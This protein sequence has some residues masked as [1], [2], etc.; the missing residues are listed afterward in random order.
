MVDKNDRSCFY[1]SMSKGEE[2]RRQ[3]VGTALRRA[4]EV[5]LEGVTVGSLADELQLSKSGLFAHFRSKEALQ[6][7]VLEEAEARFTEQ[8]VR[9]ALKAPR[10]EPRVVALFELWVRWFQLGDHPRGC[11]F[12]S[13]AAEYDDRPGAVHDGIVAS[14]KRWLEWIRGAAARAIEAGHFRADLDPGQFAFEFTAIGMSLQFQ[15]KLV[16]DPQAERRAREAFSA[17]LDRSRKAH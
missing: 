11:I 5:G 16:R 8:V 9:E 12:L 14:Q 6:L 3:I 7:A 17:L 1:L 4:G 10:G 2:T 13:L 15:S